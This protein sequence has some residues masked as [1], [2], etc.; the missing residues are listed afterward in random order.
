MRVLINGWFWDSPTGSGQYT[1]QLVHAV[2]DGHHDT[3][4]TLLRP[5]RRGPIYKLVFE[6]YVFPRRSRQYDVAHVPYWAP[7]LASSTPTV[8]TIH[9]LVPLVLPD[10]RR[11]SS[12]RAYFSIVSRASRA[13][14]A[15]ITDSAY[16][17]REIIERLGLPP[18][19]VHVIPLAAATGFVPAPQ[20]ADLLKRRRGLPERYGL[21]VGA[22]DPRKNVATLLAAWRS[23]HAR[24]GVPLVVAGRLPHKGARLPVDPRVQAHD[25]G[26][27]DEAV[28]WLA[29]VEPDELPALYSGTQVFVFPSRYEGFGL[30]PLEAMACGAPVV[31]SNAA[32]L[33]EVVGQAGLLVPPD[34]IAGWAT[35]V[36]RVLEDAE[37]RLHLAKAGRARAAQFSWRATARKTLEVYRSAMSS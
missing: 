6:Q 19:K 30:P 5:R 15:L 28:V 29:D 34:D 7:P 21:Y 27:P 26:L 35:A 18:D 1:R 36:T 20:Q 2:R 23:V 16:S 10:Y 11:A 8:V 22:F 25:V 17:R 4:V 13:A 3:D 31:C 9:D 12:V 24:T 14:K 37:F 32:S 33:P